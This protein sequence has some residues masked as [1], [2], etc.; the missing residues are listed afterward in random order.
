LRLGT[1]IIIGFFCVSLLLAFVGFISDHFTSEI[2]QEQLNSVNDA[3]EVVIYT[4]EME[5][6]LFQSLIFLNGIREA[7]IVEKNYSTIQELPAVVELKTDFEAELE[8]FETSFN[9]LQKLLGEDEL[10]PEDLNELY[11]SY[12]VYKSIS[13]QWLQLGN[14]DISQA[15]LMFINSIEPYFRNNIIPEIA[16]VRNYV[17]MIQ[18]QRNQKLDDSLETAAYIN[19]LA[20]ILSVLLAL[21]LAVYIY[22]SIANP[23]AKVSA[24]AKKLGEGELDERIEVSSKDEIGDLAEAFNSMAEG[25]QSKTVSKA[26]LDNIIESI[27][28]ALFVTDNEGML[29]RANSAAAELVGY[30]LDEMLNTPVKNYYNLEE[31]GDQYNDNHLDKGSFEFSLINMNKVAIPVLFSEAQLVDNQG[32]EV[33]RVSVA[34]DISER[35][36]QEEE[37]R[38][39]L[40]EKEVMLAEIH[41]RVKNNLAVIS[42]L[43][44]L[45]SYSTD[46]DEVEKALSDSQM[47]VQ[48]IALVHEML[49]QSESLAYIK[50][51]KYIND[52]LQAISSMHMNDKNITLS[53]EV[54]PISLS[55]N[56]A[57]PCSLLINELIVNAFKHAFNSKEEGE[58]K[59]NLKQNGD[60]ITMIISDTGN[61]FDIEKFSNSD[62]LG[63]TLIKTLSGQLGGEFEIVD[64]SENSGS[65]F[66]IK[67]V[68]DN[69][70]T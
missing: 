59:V 63:A 45:Q 36:K 65:T 23:L 52:L 62:S 66:K 4:G 35:K 27:Q 17:L 58:I 61:G 53:S 54:E 37:I 42:G 40:K 33:G 69:Y 28:E 10:L 9:N 22:K 13:R 47:R 44:Q 2:R 19:Y 20:T 41:H 70:H 14:E 56:Q 26:Y 31:M 68:R 12:E 1:K 50:Y 25:L 49:Y 8:Q 39:S 7:L 24:S 15:N 16:L 3:S 43:L 51:D 21:A 29:I 5:R 57:I 30:R 38:T 64:S 60:E 11:S 46:N 32:E 18:E 48:S 55:I 6:S 34:S 67:F